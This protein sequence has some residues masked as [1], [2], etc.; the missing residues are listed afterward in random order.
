MQSRE[1]IRRVEFGNVENKQNM[2]INGQLRFH[3]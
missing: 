1:F 3:V 2:T